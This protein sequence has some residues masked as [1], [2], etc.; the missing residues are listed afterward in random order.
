MVEEVRN[1]SGYYEDS[2]AK[3][4]MKTPSY[5]IQVGNTLKRCANVVCGLGIRKMDREMRES[6]FIF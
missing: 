3:Y 2:E 1:I 4:K 6:K 5:A